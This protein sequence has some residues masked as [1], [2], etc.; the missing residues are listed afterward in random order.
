MKQATFDVNDKMVSLSISPERATP[1]LLMVLQDNDDINVSL[2]MS[3]DEA[4]MLTHSLEALM[5]HLADEI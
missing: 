3:F 4:K 2:H 1:F 5:S